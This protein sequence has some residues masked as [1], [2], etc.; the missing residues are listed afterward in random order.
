M[1]SEAL[2]LGIVQGITEWLPV[3][4]E[5]MVVLAQHFFFGGGSLGDTIRF[6]LFLHLGTV[7]AAIVYFRTDIATLGKNLFQYQKLSQEKK[8]LLI[9]Y[10]VATLIGGLVGMGVLFLLD[11]AESVLAMSGMWVNILLGVTLAITGVLQFSKGKGGEKQEDDVRV[12][13]G[14]MI[15]FAQALAVVPGISRSGTTVATLLLRGYED[16]VALKLSFIAGIP[17]VIAGNILLNAERFV[18]SPE[19]L[20]ALLASFAFGFATI[21]LLLIVARRIQ[22]GW[23]L[24]AFAALLI[25]AGFVG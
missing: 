5:G 18:P 1:I 4:S 21:H 13:D 8:N 16:E 12:I 3:S 23:L 15:G 25:V 9:F 19:N 11:S 2:T 6:A 7:L 20:I 14:V 22:F 17:L 10:I 24:L